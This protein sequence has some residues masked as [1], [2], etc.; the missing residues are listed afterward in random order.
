MKRLNVVRV[1]NMMANTQNQSNAEV[2]NDSCLDI[3]RDDELILRALQVI[4][5]EL[6]KTAALIENST[7]ELSEKFKGLA[8]TSTEQAENI[9]K[10]T[11]LTTSLEYKGETLSLSDAFNIIST[12]INRAIEKILFVSK[13]SMAMV[14][15]LDGA[16]DMVK[17]IEGYVSKVQKITKQTSLLALNATIEASRAGEAGKG[18][19][20][21]ANEVKS[22]AKGIEELATGMRDKIGNIVTSVK[23]SHKILE[24]IATIDMGDNILVKESVGALMDSLL[25]QNEVLGTVMQEASASSRKAAEAIN[26]MVMGM[27]FQDRS[28]QTILNSVDVIGNITQTLG[29]RNEGALVIDKGKAAVLATAFRLGDLKN[30]FAIKLMEHNN[31]QSAEEIGVNIFNKASDSSAANDDDNIE[32]F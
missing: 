5:Q 12:S 16:M 10:F 28:S 1:I 20:V 24:E 21:V 8:K 30:A 11:S 6:P 22:L 31:I 2:A 13:M 23:G 32:L 15:S 27:Q 4:V 25:K 29:D 17:E 26:A 19:A 3:K 7:L 14:Y 9:E 18:F